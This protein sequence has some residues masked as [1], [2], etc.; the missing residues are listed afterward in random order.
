MKKTLP[1]FIIAVGSIIVA[2]GFNLFLISHQLLSGGASG[3]AMLI[4]YFTGWNIG[5]LYFIINVPILLWGYFVIG[6]RF[7]VLSIIS[8]VV[9]SWFMQILP[10]DDITIDPLLGAVFGGVL[11]GIGTGLCLKA[12]GSTGG[13]DIIG[14]IV[15]KR[16]DFPLG[17]VLF[18]LN[19]S[20]VFVLGFVNNWDLALYSMLAIFITGKIVDA[21][22]IRHIK[23]TVFIVTA[24]AKTLLKTMLERPRGVTLIKTQGAFSGIEKDML[25]TVTTR[26][27]L[28]DLKKTIKEVDPKAFVNIV[29]TVEVMG[30][31]RRSL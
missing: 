21:I 6:S 12:G 2:M 16:R 31:F 15:T 11:I 17:S 20:V 30:E 25:M 3:V 14:S 22:H 19:A 9:T 26:Y 8:V 18:A 13:F 28:A 10:V 7:I 1:Y 5:L 27:E 4:G 29:E 24:E 23:I